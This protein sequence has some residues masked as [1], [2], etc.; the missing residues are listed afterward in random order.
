MTRDLPESMKKKKKGPKPEYEKYRC[1]TIL[2]TYSSH[3][4]KK[5]NG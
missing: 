3:K 1:K 4:T 2:N 5:K